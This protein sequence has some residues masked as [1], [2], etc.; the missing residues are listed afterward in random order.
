MIKRCPKCDQIIKAGEL[1]QLTVIAEFV[2]LRS[3][4]HFAIDKP[5]D[6]LP[7]TLE[8]DECPRETA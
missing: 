8:H 4:I 5:I 1:V 7:E 2:D 3:K 6:S